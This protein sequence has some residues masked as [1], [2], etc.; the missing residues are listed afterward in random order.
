M[1]RLMTLLLTTFLVSCNS[2]QI[3]CDVSFAENRCRCRC[4]NVDKLKT[5][6][7]NKCE[8]DWNEYFLGVPNDHPVNYRTSRCEGISG[9][10]IEEIAKD[11]IPE[12]KEE[13]ARCEDLEV[14]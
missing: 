2:Y 4:Y 8:K 9:F 6:D 11:I 13:R 12:I 7:K 10:R 3:L 5:A 14:N 1:T